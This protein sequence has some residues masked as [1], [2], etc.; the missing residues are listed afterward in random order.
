MVSH[1]KKV[2]ITC[3][4]GLHILQLGKQ[5]S[6]VIKKVNGGARFGICNCQICLFFV[7]SYQRACDACKT[8][9]LKCDK[10]INAAYAALNE[11]RG[12][13]RNFP[14]RG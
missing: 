6:F 12:G 7:S 5:P 10:K 8:P 3:K 13:A 1:S 2:N 9:G 11:N 14:T 4:G